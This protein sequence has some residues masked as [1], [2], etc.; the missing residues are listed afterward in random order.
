MDTDLLL[1]MKYMEMHPLDAVRVLE[2]LNI[3]D[4]VSL[5]KEAS[6]DLNIE[7]FKMMDATI[8]AECF[9]A[10]TPEMSVAL[11]EKLPL[12]IV[13]AIFR[14]LDLLA[15]EVVLTRLSDDVSASIKRTL[16]FREGTAGAL[17]NPRVVPLPEDIRVEDALKR[18]KLYGRDAPNHIYLVD[19]QH[20]LTGRLSAYD[21]IFADAQTVVSALGHR[22]ISRL[23]AKADRQMILSHPGWLTS[24]TLPVVDDNGLFLGEID[25]QT[26]RRIERDRVK[27]TTKT[28]MDETIEAFGELFWL[29][30]SGLIKGTVSSMNGK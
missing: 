6:P 21:L 1:A 15:R 4:A 29:G 25:Y 14:K 28:P 2:P 17:M 26:Y 23:S 22:D 8:A 18:Y 11:A 30:L 13:S 10:M 16:G 19:R 24:H 20:V 7:I 9:A 12:E 27:H 5:L 3:H